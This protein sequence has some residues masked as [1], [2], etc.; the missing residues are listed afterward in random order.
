[1]F[2]NC[3]LPSDTSLNT[4]GRVSEMQL[5]LFL[6]YPTKLQSTFVT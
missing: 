2:T 6:F 4:D 3:S 5:I 1:M